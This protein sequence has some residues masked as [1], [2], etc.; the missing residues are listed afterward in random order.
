MKTALRDSCQ[1][2]FYWLGNDLGIDSLNQYTQAFGLGEDMG[3][4][5]KS[6]AGFMPNRESRKAEGGQWRIDSTI[7]T[8]VGRGGSAFSPLQFAEYCAV[9]ANGGS[10]Y[11]ASLTQRILDAEG[12]ALYTRLPELTAV[13]N[14]NAELWND[15]RQA[16]YERSG[17]DDPQFYPAGKMK[18]AGLSQGLTGIGDKLYMGFAPF[19]KPQIAFAVV[20]EDSLNNSSASNTAYDFVMEYQKIMENR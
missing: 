10:R 8:A 14:N 6:T 19:E 18:M 7:E 5:L 9:I 15:I 17:A 2:Y 1:F 20:F 16:M 4:E 13:G 12:N 3:I 11:S